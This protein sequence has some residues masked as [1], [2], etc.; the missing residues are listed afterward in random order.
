MPEIKYVSSIWPSIDYYSEYAIQTS[1]TL[2]W[3]TRKHVLTSAEK[4]KFNADRAS[5]KPSSC[6]QDRNCWYRAARDRANVSFLALDCAAVPELS[7]FLQK[8]GNITGLSVGCI[9]T[10]PKFVD[11]AS[12]INTALYNGQYSKYGSSSTPTEY[13]GAYDLHNSGPGLLN[14]SVFFNDTT[15]IQLGF[16]QSPVPPTIRLSGPINAIVDAFLNVGTDASSRVYASLM[17]M[18]EVCICILSILF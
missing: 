18:R 12:S 7:C 9:S 5:D 16:S 17:G 11:T 2:S 10:N 8:M 13:V 4:Q 1:S 3:W 15:E 6:E 14:V